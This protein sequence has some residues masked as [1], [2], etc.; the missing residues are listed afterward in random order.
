MMTHGETGYLVRAGDD[1][2]MAS[3]LLTLLQNPEKMCEMGGRGRR[4]VEEKFSCAA[5][6]ERTQSLYAQLL[7]RTPELLPQSG[8]HSGAKAYE[9]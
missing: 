7:K 1:E 2:T 4:V 3:R 5:Q 8:K 9:K 6:L